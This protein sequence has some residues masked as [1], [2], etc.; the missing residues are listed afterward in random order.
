[1]AIQRVLF[2]IGG[3]S[4]E[5]EISLI[6]SKYVLKALDR[7]RFEPLIVVIQK[8]GAMTYIEEKELVA[9]SNNPKKI[10]TPKGVPISIEP[11]R[12][13]KKS[14][15]ILVGEHA[16]EFDVAFPLLHGPG[17]EDGTIQGLFEF[18]GIPV[19]GCGVRA[20]AVCMDKGLT[21]RLLKEAGLPVVPFVEVFRGERSPRLS[22][23]FPV[24]VKPAT[25]GSSLGVTKVKSDGE[26]NAA[27]A[28]ALKLDTK[29]LIEPAIVGREIEIAVL[30][31]RGDLIASPAGEI[32][33]TKA[34]FYSYDAKYVD[35]NAVELL[36]PAPL[37]SDEL[38]RVQ[39][40]AKNIFNSLQCHGMARIDFFMNK[41][42]EFLL[43]E[44]NTIPGFTP[45]S[46]YPKMMQLAGVSYTD[47]ITKLI[48]LAS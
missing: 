48:E 7:K 41:S 44:V 10:D 33:V 21:K 11:Y 40:L 22:F 24:F 1:M 2:L 30:G 17:G 35:E 31:K 13:D 32:K 12:R 4:G 29:A 38:A 28:E 9:L 25:L 45:I 26:L 27:M 23:E 3:R 5:H 19:V 18:S 42:G 6:S 47:L 46:M 37:T 14:P 43:N 8:N 36:V 20:S 39:D 34:E 15:R 16:H